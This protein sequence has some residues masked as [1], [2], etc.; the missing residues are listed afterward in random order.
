M[1]INSFLRYNS[2]PKFDKLEVTYQPVAK[3]LRAAFEPQCWY[4]S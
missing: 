3:R 2:G 1:P 4:L